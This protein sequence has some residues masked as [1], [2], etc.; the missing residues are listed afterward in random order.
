MSGS[1]ACIGEKCKFCEARE[2]VPREWGD[3]RPNLFDAGTDTYEPV[4]TVAERAQMS[5]E[6][7]K[8][9][10]ISGQVD[11]VDME[12]GGWLTSI[13][14]VAEYRGR[15]VV[16]PRTRHEAYE[17][18]ITKAT[19]ACMVAIECDVTRDIYSRLNGTVR[20]RLLAENPFPK[21]E[22]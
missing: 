21:E 8:T 16:L 2:A 5:E 22:P 17:A 20:R 7:L 10:L 1:I 4:A 19:A 9:L 11:G 3:S 13:V 14:A 6:D 15:Q 12:E 18:A